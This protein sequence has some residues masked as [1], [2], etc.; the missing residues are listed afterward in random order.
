MSGFQGLQEDNTTGS[1]ANALAFIVQSILNSSA[2]CTV[3]QV[4]A[5][6]T[7]GG[8]NAPGYVDAIPLVAQVD[9]AGNT[10]PHGV[11][12]NLPFFRVQ[13]GT[14]AVILDPQPGDLGIAVI[15]HSDISSVKATGKAAPPGSRRRFDL[16]DGIYLGGILTRTPAQY[17]Q[18]NAA[19]MTLVSPALVTIDAPQ[20]VSNAPATF[21]INSPQIVLNGF[22]TQGN[23]SYGGTTTWNGNLSVNG[24]LTNNGHLVGSTHV[25]TNAGGT[26]NSGPPV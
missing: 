17:V 9:G 21:T 8:V 14:N 7:A 26:G 2:T 16:S 19:G 25:H 24:V 13:G 15:C 3:V 1:D 5:C 6:T 22:V 20:I 4:V 23:G 12:H 11:V 18:F 10:T